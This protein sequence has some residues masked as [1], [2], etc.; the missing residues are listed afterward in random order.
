MIISKG[1]FTEKKFL[2]LAG[3]KKGSPLLPIF[4]KLYLLLLE[5]MTP[6]SDPSMLESN[7]ELMQ[8][9]HESLSEGKLVYS[10]RL[11]SD[12]D[13]LESYFCTD[14]FEM[15]NEKLYINGINCVW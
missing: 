6:V 8:L 1:K 5:N 9:I 2:D 4:K 7:T 13:I 15:K 11:S 14:S 12:S 3:V 10:G